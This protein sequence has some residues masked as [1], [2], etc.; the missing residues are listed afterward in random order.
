MVTLFQYP[1]HYGLSSVSPFCTKVELYLRLAGI[2]HEVKNGNPQSSP[3]KKLPTARIEGQVVADSGLII[4]ACKDQLGIDL[5]ASLDARQRAT[6]H[7]MRRTCEENLYWALVYSRWIDEACWPQ[8]RAFL[9]GMLPPVIGPLLPGYLRSRVRTALHEHG[10][11]RHPQEMIYRIGLADQ[12]ALTALLPDEGLLFG[13]EPSTFDATV[14]AFLWHILATPTDNPLSA[15]A[16]STPRLV[17]YVRR[18]LERASWTEQAAALPP[19]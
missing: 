18:V 10:L 8:Q 12:Q 9:V 2:P 15:T 7:L 19:G 14:G 1:G 16:R 3:T 13:P 17:A 4:E 6:G 5:D 11:G